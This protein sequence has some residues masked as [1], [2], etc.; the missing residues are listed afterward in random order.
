MKSHGNAVETPSRMARVESALPTHEPEYV[1]ANTFPQIEVFLTGDEAKECLGV[2]I[3][4]QLHYLHATSSRVL[5]QR[6]HAALEEWNRTV[7]EFK[8]EHPEAEGVDRIQEV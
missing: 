1:P 2:R 3:H 6:I 5:E 7:R 8:R 4:G